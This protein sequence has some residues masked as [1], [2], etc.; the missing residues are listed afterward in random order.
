MQ[1]LGATDGGRRCGDGV[2]AVLSGVAGT[3]GAAECG[4]PLAPIDHTD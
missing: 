3:V 1:G 4:P 2:V